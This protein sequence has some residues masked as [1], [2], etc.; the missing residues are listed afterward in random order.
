MRWQR[1]IAALLMGAGMLVAGTGCSSVDTRSPSAQ[2]AEVKSWITQQMKVKQASIHE[3]EKAAGRA[4][5]TPADH[6]IARLAI[7]ILSKNVA[8]LI[9][10]NGSN[11]PA[12]LAS[13]MKEE[14]QQ[15]QTDLP[16]LASLML[17]EK[18]QLDGGKTMYRLEGKVFTSVP[19]K[20]Y[21]VTITVRVDK[22]G[23]IE[24]FEIN[25]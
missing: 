2:T 23:E 11:K 17:E 15:E 10:E 3:W 22:Q 13:V 18:S 4:N 16:S 12:L 9:A 20:L 21:P 8:S 7:N 19:D 25:K 1:T 5:T 14:K 24:Y 6:A